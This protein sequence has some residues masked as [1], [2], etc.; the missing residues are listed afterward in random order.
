M[1][2]KETLD[3][4][5]SSFN[6]PETSTPSLA[7][8]ITPQPMPSQA[9]VQPISIAPAPTFAQAPTMPFVP[10]AAQPQATAAFTPEVSHFIEFM[11]NEKSRR[12]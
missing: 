5:R 12:E 9:M 8:Q 11:G 3:Q 2:K 7:P 10:V 6:L 1:T 4:L